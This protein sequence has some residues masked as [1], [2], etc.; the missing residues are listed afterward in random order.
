MKIMLKQIKED[1][2]KFLVY[3][4]DNGNSPLACDFATNENK[5]DVINTLTKRFGNIPVVEEMSYNEYINQ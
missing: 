4:M 5:G 2:S 3:V 1:G